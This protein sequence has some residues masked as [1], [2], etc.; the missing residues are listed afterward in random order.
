M[1]KSLRQ[2]LRE[3]ERVIVERT[4]VANGGDK[5]L[6]AMALG[7]SKRA[8]YKILERH[9]LLRPRYTRLLPIPFVVVDE[10]VED[11]G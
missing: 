1:R 11:K 10:K 3:Y 9:G 6:T 4:V 5:D 7:V 2:L 8:L